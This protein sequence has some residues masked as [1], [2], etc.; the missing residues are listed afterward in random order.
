MRRGFLHSGEKTIIYMLAVHLEGI[1]TLRNRRRFFDIQ[2]TNVDVTEWLKSLILSPSCFYPTLCFCLSLK[3]YISSLMTENQ[4][5]EI[6][7]ILDIEFKRNRLWPW[8]F[9]DRNISRLIVISAKKVVQVFWCACGWTA[10]QQ[11]IE[12]QYSR[13]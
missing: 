1:C 10:R 5:L 6:D 9:Q 12:P 4:S 2:I 13:S 11:T 3:A 7:R 8:N